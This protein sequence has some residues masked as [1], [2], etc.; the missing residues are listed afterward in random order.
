MIV[1]IHCSPLADMGL[2]GMGQGDRRWAM[3]VGSIGSGKAEV[4]SG[5]AISSHRVD[6]LHG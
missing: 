4:D 1:W 2:A 5:I 3:V 6:Y